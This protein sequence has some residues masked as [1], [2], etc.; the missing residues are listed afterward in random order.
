M[1]NKNIKLMVTIIILI[2][3]TTGFSIMDK[4]PIGN[5]NKNVDAN[6]N[7][8]PVNSSV[9]KNS[10]TP[11]Q[12]SMLDT[13][14][15]S[16]SAQTSGTTN[17]LLT[18]YAVSDQIGWAAGAGPTVVKTSNGGI[19]WTSATGTGLTGTIYNIFAWSVND[20][21][22]A[23]NLASTSIYKTSNGGV[24][25]AQVFNQVGGFINAVH[26]TSA[27]EGYG[28]GDPVGGKWTV[29][30]TTDGGNT[31]ARMATEPT[32]VGA[33]AG[34]NN[35][36]QIEGTN[37]WFGTS[38][39]KVYHS[40]NLGLTWTSAAT[41]GTLN[42]YA[43]HFS[44]LTNGLA[45]GNAMVK[46]TD[47]GSSYVS[48]S[49]PGTTGNLNGLEGYG[50][51]WWGLRSDANVYRSINHG[52]NWTI[53]YNLS[54]AVW[55]DIDFTVVSGCSKGWAV[56]TGGYIA[57]MSATSVSMDTS[58][59]VNSNDWPVGD[60]PLNPGNMA[61]KATISN[62]GL[63]NITT[64]FPITYKISGPVN[65]TSTKFDTLGAG[66]TKTIAFDSTFNPT[67]TG[68]YIVKIFIGGGIGSGD[69][70]QSQ[71]V[72]RAAMNT[73]SV[74][75]VPDGSCCFKINLFSS[76]GYYCDAIK[77]TPIVPTTI[78]S[79]NPVNSTTVPAIIPPAVPSVMWKSLA[80]SSFQQ[81]IS[82]LGR[83]CF[84]NTS[85]SFPV[86][87]QYSTN[88]G[89]TFVSTNT[90][91][92]TC[93]EFIPICTDFDNRSTG[94]WLGRNV[95][96]T[97]P[98]P[99]PG[100]SGLATDYYLRVKDES[101]GS[102]VYATAPYAGNWINSNLGKCICWDYRLFNDGNPS[103]S[104]AVAPRIAILQGFNP[105]LP[106]VWGTN[107]VRGAVFVSNSTTTESGGWVNTCAPIELCC[108]GSTLPG[109][110][111]GQW[112]TYPINNSCSEWTALLNNVTHLYF[113]VDLTSFQTE[114]M[115]WDN[116]CIENCSSNCNTSCSTSS[117][118][119]STGFNHK[120]NSLYSVDTYDAYWELVSS[121]IAGLHVPRPAGVIPADPAWSPALTNSKWLAPVIYPHYKYPTGF[122]NNP[123]P[124][125]PYTFQTCFCVCQDNSCISINLSVM[126]DDSAAVYL[127][128]VYIPSS[129][130]ISFGS[131][132]TVTL[133]TTLNAGEHCLQVRVRNLGGDPLGIKV[134]GTITGNNLVKHNCCDSTSCFTGMKF[135]DKNRNGIRE[136]NEPGL[137][138]WPIYLNGSA[139]PSAFTDSWGLYTLCGLTSSQFYS[140]SERTNFFWRN[141]TPRSYN[142]YLQSSEVKNFDFGN[143]RRFWFIGAFQ[144]GPVV[145]YDGS[146][147]AELRGSTSPYLK[148]DSG[149]IYQDSL[150][151]M[152]PLFTN[153][154]PSGNYYAV[155][156]GN[157][158]IE[159]WS[160]ST[161][162]V[163]T[164]NVD[165]LYNFT[166]SQS[167]AF[168]NNL[169]FVNGKWSFYIGDVTQDG[170]I[171]GSDI[172]LIDN[173]ATNFVTGYAVSDLNEDGVVDASDI[174]FADNNAA[175]FITKISP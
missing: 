168:G 121:P 60:I 150:G 24:T 137:Q 27:T 90:V 28:L 159:T 8:V 117:L 108:N 42:T 1:K 122:G 98:L 57:R 33:E 37:M 87:F 30:K 76:Y 160:A 101:G 18:I 100:S 139:T 45:G 126:A 104:T 16:W 94:P 157:N 112:Q 26:M 131:P 173:D 91:N 167:Q 136:T 119:V 109:N 20:A 92:V 78:I 52:A 36:F 89:V 152:T 71:F 64:P 162:L 141:T 128:G 123:P 46:S 115:G 17:A 72:V 144:T 103:A 143:R 48:T 170:A 53:A 129:G 54:G 155:M 106:F 158:M 22:C 153:D 85:G 134:Q 172:A 50:S 68:I 4:I 2:F 165:S 75:L 74:S 163:D 142:Y 147:R 133:N 14:S 81:G 175:N 51:D 47:G 55:Q 13:C 96:I 174:L 6:Q 151:V 58:V 154:V 70:L 5:N 171:D 118:N 146:L 110:S 77:I 7:K 73:I 69:T 38:E 25:W 11:I 84:S 32:Q 15:Y 93:A 114:L 120:T 41:T 88:G 3:L 19:N 164:N 62:Y 59:T 80:G 86:S 63:T 149:T 125:V 31:W 39:T 107:P 67:D 35:S 161:I 61:P 127:D 66:S 97:S 102:F 12:N 138:N 82:Y 113:P 29:V 111:Q 9:I 166:T 23:S 21:I 135:W 79:V 56:G 116:I 132:A 169:T 145:R 44:S 10:F 105:S 43:L 130:I 65:Y 83:V 34:W 140:I 40:T 49:S 124:A 95:T 148:L 156:K 99:S